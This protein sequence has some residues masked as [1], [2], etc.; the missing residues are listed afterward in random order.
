MLILDERVQLRLVRRA[1]DHS[2]AAVFDHVAGVLHLFG[3]TRSGWNGRFPLDRVERAASPACRRDEEQRREPVT[4]LPHGTVVRVPH[5]EDAGRR[6]EQL[7]QTLEA[8]QR[9]VERLDVL[10]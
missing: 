2:H 8:G 3:R 7:L 1:E 10:R 9:R 6:R 4:Y 5:H